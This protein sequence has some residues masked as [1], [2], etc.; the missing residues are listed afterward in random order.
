ME[1]A[2]GQL[3]SARLKRTSDEQGRGTERLPREMSRWAGTIGWWVSENKVLNADKE[4]MEDEWKAAVCPPT[5]PM[6]FPIRSL[7]V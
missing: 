7:C 1:A 3:D 4:R 5:L 2:R 6:T